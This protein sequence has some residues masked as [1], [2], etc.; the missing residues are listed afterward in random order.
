MQT[1]FMKRAAFGTAALLLAGVVQAA[2]VP[3]QGTW[4]TTLKARDLN[5]DGV[6]DA[7]YDTTLDVTWLR[8]GNVN[9][10][11]TWDSAVSWADKFKIGGYSDWR[12][13]TMIDTGMPGCDWS[14]GGTD[15]GYNPQTKAGTTIYSELAHLYYVTLGNKA[16]YDAAGKFQPDYGPNNSGDFQNVAAWAYW[17][18]MEYGPDHN[19]AWRSF[20]WAGHQDSGYKSYGLLAF[21]VRPGDVTAVPEPQAVAMMLLGLGVV[22]VAVRRRPR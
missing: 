16:Y 3:G 22:L 20:T 10:F 12:L 2:G 4:E 6:P 13:P 8:D 15:C 5:R 19:Q 1:N 7:F 18:G 11:M 9:G 21:A 14:N 17:T